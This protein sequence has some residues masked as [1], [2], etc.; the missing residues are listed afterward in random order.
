M[1]KTTNVCMPYP[2]RNLLHTYLFQKRF[3]NINYNP[4]KKKFTLT[5]DLQFSD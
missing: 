2:K 1:S 4:T 3:N 5:I